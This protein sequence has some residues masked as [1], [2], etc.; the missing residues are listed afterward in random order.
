MLGGLHLAHHPDPMRIRK[1]AISMDHA[2]VAAWLAAY[3]EAWKSYD[4]A[5]IGRLFSADAEY[6]YHPWDAPVRGR[7]A[8]V[9]S[10]LE[11]GNR[12]APGTYDAGYAPLVVEGRRA[13]ATGRSRY[14]AADG[15]SLVREFRNAFVLAFNADGECA[16]FT[17]WFMQA[18][19]GAKG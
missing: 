8:I 19:D 4:P 3:V 16:E 12:D 2:A 14:F 18:P 13:V 6:R 7:A 11:E 1:D 15:A 5:A 17:E 9:A 10:W